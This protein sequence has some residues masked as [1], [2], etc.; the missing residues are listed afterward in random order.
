MTSGDVQRLGI[1]A[2][3]VLFGL[4]FVLG[5]V[6]ILRGR[7]NRKATTYGSGVASA[8]CLGYLLVGGN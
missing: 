6:E 2:L 4:G 1:I 5:L 3:A 7:P 8:A